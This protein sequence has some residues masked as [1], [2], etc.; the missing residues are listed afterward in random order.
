MNPNLLSAY[1]L[2]TA[3]ACI[4]LAILFIVQ[5]EMRFF[6]WAVLAGLGNRLDFQ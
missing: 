4:A 2:V 1:R 3:V 6:Y 5:A